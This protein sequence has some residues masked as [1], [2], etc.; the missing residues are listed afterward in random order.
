MGKKFASEF[1]KICAEHIFAEVLNIKSKKAALYL[2]YHERS[3]KEK[4]KAWTNSEFHLRVQKGN[5][6]GEK[7]CNA[8]KKVFSE[9]IPSGEEGQQKAVLIGTDLPDISSKI[10]TDAISALEDSDIVIGP[11]T[12]GGYYL[13][14]M[15][16][17]Y[18]ELFTNIEWSTSTVFE[19]TLKKIKNLDLNFG[20]LPE[21]TDIDTEEDLKT[22]LNKTSSPKIKPVR[23]AIE[24]FCLSFQVKA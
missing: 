8:F 9:L 6:I 21:L 16:K 18:G 4:I 14:G 20:V 24:S 23:A 15:K 19:K 7:M 11:S 13:I 5:N 17:L 12:D 10:I 3:D 22:W 2:F 1:Y